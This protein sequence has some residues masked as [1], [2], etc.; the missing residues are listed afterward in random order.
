MGWVGWQV[1][2]W[3]AGAVT[4][5][6][7]LTAGWPLLTAAHATD[8]PRRSATIAASTVVITTVAGMAVNDLVGLPAAFRALWALGTAG[9]ACWFA[10]QARGL[11]TTGGFAARTGTGKAGK[12]EKTDGDP[13][14]DALCAQD[15]VVQAL[16]VA[17]YALQMGDNHRASDAVDGALQRSRAALDALLR[18]RQRGDFVRREPVRSYRTVAD[19]SAARH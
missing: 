11:A 4:V 1:V 13:D 15:D 9:A 6:A 2:I 7:V 3:G 16:V 18:E 19:V 14:G 10:V 17:A 12:A 5:T 8:P